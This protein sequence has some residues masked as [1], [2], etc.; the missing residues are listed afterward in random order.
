VFVCLPFLCCLSVLQP[1][2][3]GNILPPS[4]LLLFKNPAMFS[5]ELL[6]ITNPNT[7]CNKP[8]DH[9]LGLR[10]SENH[11]AL[12]FYHL[13]PHFT[14]QQIL[15][16]SDERKQTLLLRKIKTKQSAV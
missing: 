1:K 11:K 9:K 5:L 13:Q 8:E 14:L 2:L 7:R 4:S 3:R 10:L 12:L 6:V 15:M 16:T